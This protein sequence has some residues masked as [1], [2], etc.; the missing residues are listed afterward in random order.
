MLFCD[1]LPSL[2]VTLSGFIH[3]VAPVSPLSLFWLSD[4]PVNASVTLHLSFDRHLTC[5]SLLI[6]MHKAAVHMYL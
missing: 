1:W 2:S 3:V 4:T 5:V 6:I